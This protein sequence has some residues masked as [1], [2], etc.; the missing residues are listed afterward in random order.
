M[1]TTIWSTHHVINCIIANIWNIFFINKCVCLLA[2]WLIW[3]VGQIAN[4]LWH[5]DFDEGPDLRNMQNIVLVRWKSYIGPR[6]KYY[7]KI[8]NPK[9]LLLIV[10]TYTYVGLFLVY[11]SVHTY[12]VVYYANWDYSET[13]AKNI[14]IK[15]QFE[16]FD[17][18]LRRK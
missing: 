16:M 9:S 11:R 4:S 5:K 10:F 18:P 12:N 2:K 3:F 13:T 1:N 15:R 17:V 14:C 8:R 7:R 6:C